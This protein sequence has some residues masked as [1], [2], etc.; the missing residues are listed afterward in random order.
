MFDF[1]YF[2]FDL[3]D[4]SISTWERKNWIL[5]GPFDVACISGDSVIWTTDSDNTLATYIEAVCN[6]FPS[7]SK[8]LT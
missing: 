1:V 3:I 4:M 2:N 7:T 8:L 6:F 5:A